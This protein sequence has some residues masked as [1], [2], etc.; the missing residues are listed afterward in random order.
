MRLLTVLTCLVL[1]ACSSEVYDLP[2]VYAPELSKTI[3][4]AKTAANEVKLVGPVEV[5]AVRQAHP[6]GPGPYILCI[7]GT[8]S[9]TGTRTFAVFFKNN[10]YVTTRTPVIID[11]CEAQPFT[12]LGIGPFP[13]AVKPQPSQFQ[14]GV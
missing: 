10:D 7:R 13:E 12:P 6:L 11:D 2:P 4:G 3:E 1:G 9:L 8:N 5:S 14:G